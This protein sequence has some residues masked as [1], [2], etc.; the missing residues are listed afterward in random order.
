MEVTLLQHRLVDSELR[1][2][3]GQCQQY[4]TKVN[5]NNEDGQTQEHVQV[6]LRYP[7]QGNSEYVSSDMAKAWN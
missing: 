1:V 2:W 3:W 5:H 6:N 4:V 7:D